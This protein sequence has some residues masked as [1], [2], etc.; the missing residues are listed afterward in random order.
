MPRQVVDKTY[1]NT[2]V[3]A[4]DTTVIT[5]T[6]QIH[7]VFLKGAIPQGTYDMAYPFLLKAASSSVIGGFRGTAAGT[8]TQ[9]SYK[10]DGTLSNMRRVPKEERLLGAKDGVL[11]Y[12]DENNFSPCRLTAYTRNQYCPAISRTA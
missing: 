9:L 10:K 6:G 2:V 8:G 3:G 4:E 12:L 5:P 11:G 1:V 7:A